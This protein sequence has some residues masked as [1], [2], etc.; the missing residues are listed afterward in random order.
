[1]KSGRDVIIHRSEAQVLSAICDYLRL[2]RYYFWRQNNGGTFD[3][4]KGAYRKS[5]ERNLHS[6]QHFFIER[7]FRRAFR[8][9]CFLFWQSW[10]VNAG[11]IIAGFEDL[12]FVYTGNSTYAFGSVVDS[13]R[14][15]VK[16]GVWLQD[17]VFYP[18]PAP[19]GRFVD[20]K[21]W[22][23]AA[24]YNFSFCVIQLSIDN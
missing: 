14:L 20:F 23:L 1:M 2:K 3:A 18:V 5:H 19:L 8:L 22:S 10:S 6:E 4:A 21:H 11:K 24:H 16:E 17:G 7:I 9:G 12:H 13:M 15:S